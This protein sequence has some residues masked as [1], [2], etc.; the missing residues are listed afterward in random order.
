MEYFTCMILI[1]QKFTGL[2][3]DVVRWVKDATLN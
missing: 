1:F 3:V 2:Y